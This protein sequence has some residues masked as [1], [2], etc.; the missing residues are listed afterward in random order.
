M[1]AKDGVEPS[2]F[3]GMNPTKRPLLNNALMVPVMRLALTT[4]SF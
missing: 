1:E 2:T 4:F 3:R